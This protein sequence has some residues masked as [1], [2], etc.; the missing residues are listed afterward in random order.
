V[1]EQLTGLVLGASTQDASL[2]VAIVAA[3]LLIPL[4]IPRIPLVIVVVLVIDA[5]DQTLL[6]TFTEIDTSETGS[7]QSVDKAL[8]IYYLSIGYLS[9]MRNWTSHPAFR[10]GQFLF[11]YRLVGV[12][13]FEL[14]DERL[15]LLLFPN[16]FEYFFIAYETARLRYEPS[17]FSARFWLLMAAGLWIFV[18]L[19][20][21]YW[22]HIAKLDFTDT[23]SDYPAF[24]VAVVL[25][26]VIAALVLVFVV[27]PR[28]PAPDWGWRLEADRLPASLVDAHAR[29]ARR[30]ESGRVLSKEALEKVW[31]LALLCTIFASILPD[32]DATG[33][34]ILIG[35][36]AIVLA[37]AAISLAAARRGGFGLESAAARYAAL[38]ATNLGLVYLANALL[39][40]RRDFDLGY[41]LFF[42]FLITT[43]IWLYDAFRP[44]YDVRF[45]APQAR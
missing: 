31:L 34:Q 41:G 33:L 40:E 19:P 45:A 16:T 25:A 15:M 35:V 27:V 23:V 20:Q 42:A 29:Y 37:N 43:I 3:R 6:A 44:V 8:D 11:Y 2:V 5:V 9:M 14:T 30:L 26:L 1:V 39:G 13:L 10:I 36:T 7:Y 28:L 24:G 38:L 18:K 22:I 12:A 17:R 21:E 32:I 4:L